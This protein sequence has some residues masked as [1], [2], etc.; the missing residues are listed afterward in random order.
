MNMAS[1]MQDEQKSA[2]MELQTESDTPI[3]KMKRKQDDRSPLDSSLI[4]D[5][6][7]QYITRDSADESANENKKKLDESSARVFDSKVA[8]TFKDP[9]FIAKITPTLLDLMT[10]VID[11]CIAKAV[12]AFQTSIVGPLLES[13][14]KLLEQF[15]SQSKTI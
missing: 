1:S 13:N 3:S 7:K 15:E 12:T 5:F 4:P 2:D 9:K 14:N 8:K 6:K 10:P 11:S